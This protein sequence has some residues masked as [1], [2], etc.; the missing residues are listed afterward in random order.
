MS[1]WTTILASTA[2]IA[3]SLPAIAADDD[4][5]RN[6]ELK[7]GAAAPD[8]AGKTAADTSPARP[9]ARSSPRERTRR[10]RARR[11]RSRLRAGTRRASTAAPPKRHPSRKGRNRASA[12]ATGSGSAAASGRSSRSCPAAASPPGLKPEEVVLAVQTELKR[13]GCDPGAI[14]GD[15]GGR[16][17]EALAAFGHFAKVDVRQARADAGSP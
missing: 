8:A 12:R 13:V 6:I 4:L 7:P 11:R 3:F 2:I 17:R 1:R 16:S 9:R 15:W 14:D 5:P 10:R